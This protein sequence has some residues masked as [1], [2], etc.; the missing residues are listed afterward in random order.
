M[1]FN[2]N[3]MKDHAATKDGDLQYRI[4]F[5]KQKKGEYTVQKV[6]TISTYGK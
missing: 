6:K 4:I 5:P 2:E 1:H 3:K